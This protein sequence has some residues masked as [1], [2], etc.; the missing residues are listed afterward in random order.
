VAA[1]YILIS[2]DDFDGLLNFK[3][4]ESAD[5][6][7]DLNSKHFLTKSLD[8]PA[9]DLLSIRLRTKK[10]F[11]SEFTCLH[12]FVISQRCNQ[13]CAYCQVSSRNPSDV[14][15][16]MDMETAKRSVDMAL[17][18]PAKVLK[19]E[20]QGGEPLL[21]FETVRFIVEYSKEKAKENGTLIEYVLCTN[22]TLATDDMLRYCSDNNILI[23][24]SLDG[25][26]NV[27][28]SNRRYRDGTGSYRSF[29]RGLERARRYV[30]EENIS[31]LMTATRSSLS[32]S[33]EIVDE[34]VKNGLNSIFLRSLN[35]FGY[36][37]DK[38]SEIGYSSSEFVRFYEESLDYII[39]V[40]QGVKSL[41]EALAMVFL[42]RILTPYGGGF[43]D[44]Q[45]PAGTGISCIVYSH[46]G[47][48]YLSDESRMLAQAGD[49][50]FCVGN[51]HHHS[52][53]DIFFNKKTREIIAASCAEVVPGCSECVFQMYCGIDP[54]RNFAVHKD[55]INNGPRDDFCFIHKGILHKLFAPILQNNERIMDV[56]WSWLTKRN[57]SEMNR[58]CESYKESP[59]I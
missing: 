17:R 56:F 27:H 11:L 51:V 14:A 49:Q 58:I 21:N 4:R 1:E 36:A 10:Q 31:A 40:N 52:Y 12:M 6:Y 30:S 24:T 39:Q 20:F 34:Y 53:R 38:W 16:D 7:Q 2:G 8:E 47:Y 25:P 18:S 23:S 3:L 15:G 42:T 50:T 59:G 29:M 5:I 48:V 54:V 55:M 33:K 32:H 28:D 46:D 45:F 35:P 57:L 13:R 41:E 37:L 9:T 43:V 26:E 44:L 19:F 22:L